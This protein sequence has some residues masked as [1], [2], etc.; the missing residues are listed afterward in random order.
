MPKCVTI[1]RII[2]AYGGVMDVGQ[3]NNHNFRD[4]IYRCVKHNH[5]SF[6][7]KLINVKDGI[8]KHFWYDTGWKNFDKL[9]PLRK[10]EAEALLELHREKITIDSIYV[11]IEEGNESL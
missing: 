4:R 1:K 10:G 2:E 8:V 6:G 11:I 9:T 5:S 7:V 3:S